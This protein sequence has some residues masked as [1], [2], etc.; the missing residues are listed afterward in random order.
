ME[1]G[2][3]SL[4]IVPST[5]IAQIINFLVLFGLLY[6]VAYKPIMRMLDERSNKIKESIDQTEHIKEQAEHAEK[7]TVKKIKEA[8][9][10]G[11]EASG[12]E[13]PSQGGEEEGS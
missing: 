3:G 6:F 7:E 8:S 4:G 10:E 1:G 13:D 2:L 11:L 5:L 9:Q 12:E